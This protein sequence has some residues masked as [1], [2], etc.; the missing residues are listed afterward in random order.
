MTSEWL[1]TDWWQTGYCDY[2]LLVLRLTGDHV[3]L[4]VDWFYCSKEWGS[5]PTSRKPS[6]SSSLN[7]TLK[8][9]NQNRFWP[10]RQSPSHLSCTH[11]LD[12]S[13]TICTL[14]CIVYMCTLLQN[15]VYMCTVTS[16]VSNVHNVHN[17]TGRNGIKC[18]D[19][20]LY[21]MTAG[22]RW[23]VWKSPVCN[24]LKEC[25]AQ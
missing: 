10:L 17:G 3:Y 5:T 23:A 15:T 18:S 14:Q 13:S 11:S 16:T 22:G 8:S 20:N 24:H 4:V 7:P 25:T 6:D 19:S 9:P 21:S 2:V 1:V 12:V